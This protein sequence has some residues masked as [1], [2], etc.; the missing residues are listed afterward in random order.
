MLSSHHSTQSRQFMETP[1]RATPLPRWRTPEEREGNSWSITFSDLVLLLLCFVVLWHVADKRHWQRLIL[2]QEPTVSRNPEMR[3]ASEVTPHLINAK[4]AMETTQS[5]SAKQTEEIP[6]HT[7]ASSVDASSASQTSTPDTEWQELQSEIRQH[8]AEQGLDRS[9]G[10]IS[11]EQGLVISLSD[12][13]TFPSGQATF[14][15]WWVIVLS[16]SM[17]GTGT[18]VGGWRIIR[19]LGVGFYRV[20]P[21]HGF[22]AQVSSAAV[23]LGASLAGG[24][25]STSQVVSAS[26]VG[27]GAAE[28]KSKVRWGVLGEIALAWLVLTGPPA[29]EAPSITAAEETCAVKPWIGRTL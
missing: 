1:Q 15:P 22:T 24:P 9:V 29:S 13:I 6:T 28:R 4:P 14:V 27:A 19:T 20:R 5:Q 12:T 25:V 23:I 16:A 10:V 7:L 8:I 11:T 26:I 3:E 17:I 2:S 21:I 18:A